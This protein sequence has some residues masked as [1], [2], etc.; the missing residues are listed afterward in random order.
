MSRHWRR[1]LWIA[2]AVVLGVLLTL[3]VGVRLAARQLQSQTPAALGPDMT[4][5]A[6][7]IGSI[8]AE[9]EGVPKA[10][11]ACRANCQCRNVRPRQRRGHGHS[12]RARRLISASSPG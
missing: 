6:V 2:L 7:A 12:R 3:A 10:A 1:W 8:G 9:L 11:P 4:V 5:G